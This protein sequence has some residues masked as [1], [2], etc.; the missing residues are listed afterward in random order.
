MVPPSI[1]AFSVAPTYGNSPYFLSATFSNKYLI[2][3]INYKIVVNFSTAVSSCP[4][5]GLASSLSSSRLKTLLSSGSVSAS[6][7]VSAGSCRTYTLSI[8]RVSDGA[9]IATSNA[10][11]SNL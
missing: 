2:D 3:D 5:Q 10:Y 6:V 7:N 8:F 1:V 9:V 11:V 4:V